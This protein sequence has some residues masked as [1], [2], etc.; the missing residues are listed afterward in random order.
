M[1]FIGIVPT[2]AYNW[3]SSDK[4]TTVATEQIINGLNTR[5]ELAAHNL[6][7]ILTQRFL[8]IQ[9][10]ANSPVFLLAPEQTLGQGTFIQDYLNELTKVDSGF[11]RIDLI[12]LRQQ[13][14]TLV[15]GSELSPKNT[16]THYLDQTGI[17]DLTDALYLLTSGQRH[18]V[19]SEPH[20]DAN[21][22]YLFIISPVIHTHH[23]T[24]DSERFLVIKYQLNELNSQL[25]FLGERISD[26]DYIMLINEDGGT[27]LAGRHQGKD[28]T[29]FKNI[30]TLFQDR[31]HQFAPLQPTVNNSLLSFQNWQGETMLA[32]LVPLT[33]QQAGLSRWTLVSITPKS[34]V[35]T[36]LVYLQRYFLIALLA[37]A[38][39][40]I[41]LSLMLSRRIT[42][43]IAKLSR[44]AAQFKLG[45]Y[46]RNADFKGPYEFQ[47]LHD[48]LNQ[49][50]DKIS[51]DKQLLNQALQKAE[52]ADRAKSAFLANLSHEIR[53]PM[54]GM[55]G[56]TQLLLKTDLSK[57]QKQHLRTLL[58][59]G[60]HMMGLL[61]D[62]LD[63]SK[64]ERGQLTLDPTHFC[65]TD[66]I[67]STDS[68][69]HSLAK[70]KGIGF[71]IHCDF[72]QQRWFYADKAR[73]RQILFNI[74][75]NAIKFTENGRVDINLSLE[76]HGE[77]QS[78]HLTIIIKDT[79][80]GIAPDRIHS[81]FDPFAQAEASTSRR[82]G[83]TGL[84]LSIVKQ[85]TQLMQGDIHISSQPGMGSSFTI[86]LPLEHG[87]YKEDTTPIPHL[88]HN[89]FDNLNV[90]IVEDN[91]LNVMIID[92]FLKHR[93]FA[94]SV[95]E[96]GANALRA[97]EAQPFDLILM[98]N[99][100]PVMD[101]VEAIK[102]IRQLPA[103]TCD[104]PIFACTADVFAETQ[105]KMLDAGA[106]CVITK[107]LDEQKLVDALLRFK[108]QITARK[109][110]RLST[111]Q[112]ALIHTHSGSHKTSATSNISR[113][114]SRSPTL[115]D[116]TP[117]RTVTLDEDP[118][119]DTFNQTNRSDGDDSIGTIHNE[120][121][122]LDDI[123]HR[124][125]LSAEH[126]QHVELVTLLDLMDND[127]DI[128]IEFLHMFCEEH[129]NDAE[130]FEHSLNEPTLDN[131]L[132]ISHS[133]KGAAGSISAPRVYQAAMAI[134]KQ[135]KQ[136]QRPSS[137]D[138]TALKQTL[139]ELVD[140]IH[141]QLDE[142]QPSP[143]RQ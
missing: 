25:T 130:R 109:Q 62:I 10:L 42:V 108:P 87:H 106:Q 135:I 95:A 125:S 72:D 124:S 49:G 54:N 37:T 114:N 73:I 134:E 24:D 30:D 89:T 7:D 39:V 92:S 116:T 48:A 142:R 71:H 91:H 133:L 68:T 94:T 70:E 120:H 50:A 107:P 139:N 66:L 132:L 96:N 93:S 38:S 53:T 21:N 102:R 6:D 13:H 27:V 57:E 63:F 15:A 16:L 3:L 123:N 61:N 11:S 20:Y 41:I 97:I 4:L 100:M 131:A 85:L 143:P 51:I 1:L 115:P 52:S 99:H 45:N 19:F 83:G 28:V 78:Q 129:G 74:I 69:Y 79:G 67:D 43:P 77:T 81:I 103:P 140:E 47:V 2:V 55:L 46:S 118:I 110:Q 64:I 119:L 86:S 18:L 32:T 58:D 88:D 121:R 82:F 127:H 122:V 59:S 105:Q 111:P 44:F 22:A 104:T 9:K 35:T 141:Q 34:A 112:S 75:S 65:F 36:T 26:T 80:I 17:A 84:G 117:S 23:E 5:T 128:V 138:I 137:D 113:D 33:F 90:L 40:V 98:D 29:T 12:E 101:G 76:D 56:L 14:I 8:S 136:Q 31:L 60:N 126:F